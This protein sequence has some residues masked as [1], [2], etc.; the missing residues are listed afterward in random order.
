[1]KRLLLEILNRHATDEEGCLQTECSTC[2]FRNTAVRLFTSGTPCGLPAA[3]DH[4][5]SVWKL[6]P[7]FWKDILRELLFT[8]KEVTVESVLNIAQKRYDKDTIKK[9]REEGIRLKEKKQRD[10]QLE[11]DCRRKP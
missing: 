10:K 1:M 9:H 5:Q 6:R 2:P 4:A 8:D 7:V 11:I 3:Y